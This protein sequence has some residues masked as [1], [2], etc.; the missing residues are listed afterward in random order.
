MW[1][2][3]GKKTGQEAKNDGEW[4]KCPLLEKIKMHSGDECIFYF[5]SKL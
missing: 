1:N 3:T 4:A 5:A 2:N